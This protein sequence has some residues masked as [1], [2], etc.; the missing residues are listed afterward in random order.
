[1]KYMKQRTSNDCSIATLAMFL[2]AYRAEPLDELYDTIL[3]LVDNPSFYHPVHAELFHLRAQ[4]LHAY[5]DARVCL[6]F[7][8]SLVNNHE[9]AF[10][11]NSLLSVPSKNSSGQMHSV[12]WHA[13]AGQL[14]DPANQ[15]QYTIEDVEKAILTPQVPG[16]EIW[17]YVNGDDVV[18]RY[19]LKKERIVCQENIASQR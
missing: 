3:S 4:G 5:F 14:I 2:S 18:N 15:F 13:E 9:F 7:G 6:S 17:V 10:D 11:L 8:I 19:N 1:M 16:K 12:I